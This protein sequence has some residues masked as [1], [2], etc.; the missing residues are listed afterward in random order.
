MLLSVVVHSVGE[1][2][3]VTDDGILVVV[4]VVV[5]I[6]AV[7]IDD[8]LETLVVVT[9]ASMDVVVEVY[10]EDNAKAGES[11]IIW[12]VSLFSS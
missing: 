7:T 5:V 6:V 4:V 3:V 1:L 10:E 8:T 12:F 9:G 11:S 2:V